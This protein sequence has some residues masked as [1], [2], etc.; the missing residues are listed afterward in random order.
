VCRKDAAKLQDVPLDA[1][2]KAEDAY[3]KAEEL[4]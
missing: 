1:K 3:H 4:R 2:K